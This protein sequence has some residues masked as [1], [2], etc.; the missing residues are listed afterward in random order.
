MSF[1]VVCS[2]VDIICIG[3]AT[4]VSGAR[5]RI[6]LLRPSERQAGV[7]Y[8]SAGNHDQGVALASSL[9]DIKPTIMMP[10]TTPEIKIFQTKLYG[11]PEI[12][13]Y[14]MNFREAYNH[15]RELHKERGRIFIHPYDDPAVIAGQGTVGLEILEQWPDVDTILV[16]VGGGGFIAGITAAV[17]SHHKDIQ[18]IGAR[19]QNVDAAA[20]SIEQKRQISLKDSA[21]I[22]DGINISEIGEIPFSLPDKFGVSIIRVSEEQIS[23]SIT[24][25]CQTAQLV[26]EPAGA[27]TAAAV[28][29]HSEKLSGGRNMLVS[30]RGLTLIYRVSLKY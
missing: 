3:I 14:G 28:L 17:L 4:W 13:L 26:I 29:Y 7:I 1:A 6:R 2:A 12:I 10:I 20:Q 21:T 18:V 9:L 11:K 15:A 22:A 19:A 30:C 8:A 16:P 27:A 23:A 24:A 5:N 25:L